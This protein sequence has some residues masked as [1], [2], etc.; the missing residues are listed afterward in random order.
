M[1][2]SSERVR[3]QITLDFPFYTY[4]NTIHTHDPPLGVLLCVTL[5]NHGTSAGFRVPGRSERWVDVGSSVFPWVT[6][7]SPR[8]QFFFPFAAAFAFFCSVS[9]FFFVSVAHRPCLGLLVHGLLCLQPFFP[10]GSCLLVVCLALLS[11]LIQ[12]FRIE[13][14][15]WYWIF[16]FSPFP[17]SSRVVFFP[18]LSFIR[19]SCFVCL[20][21][22]RMATTRQNTSR[23]SHMDV[24]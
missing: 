13:Q 19:L 8:L 11:F 22:L 18:L 4:S 21:Q 12:H 20:L 24:A 6:L 3:V 16:L 1:S 10:R 15:C 9:V 5:P 2:Y 17:L 23:H 14:P 7:F